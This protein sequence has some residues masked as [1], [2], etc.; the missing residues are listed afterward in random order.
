MTFCGDK[1]FNLYKWEMMC[2]W[3]RSL[4]FVQ[5][6]LYLIFSNHGR[7]SFSFFLDIGFI[8]ICWS[9]CFSTHFMECI[10]CQTWHETG[11]CCRQICNTVY[12]FHML[13]SRLVGVFRDW[14][15]MLA[16][17][18]GRNET[19]Q[20]AQLLPPEGAVPTFTF[21]SSLLTFCINYRNW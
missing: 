17:L 11:A 7:T 6:V 15:M 21:C 5:H 9:F 12:N 10:L 8:W 19:R 13:T 14:T 18:E 1:N 20:W 2:G 16:L 4:S 3:Q